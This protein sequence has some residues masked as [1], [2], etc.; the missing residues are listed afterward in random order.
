MTDPAEKLRKE[1]DEAHRSIIELHALIV[2]RD[3]GQEQQNEREL[4]EKRKG[5]LLMLDK[6]E[7]AR[8]QIEQA[9]QEWMAA[10]DAVDDPIFLH[11]KEFRIVRANRAYQRCAGIPFKEIIG[12]PYYQVFPKTDGPLPAC[13][14]TVEE[15][16]KEGNEEEV[17]LGDRIYR[18]RAFPVR[19]EQGDFL[20]SVHSLEDVTE[21]MEMELNLRE[22]EERYRT[23][24]ENM[25]NAFAYCRMVFE[26]GRPVDFIYLD[27]N[28][29]LRETY[30]D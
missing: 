2:K 30:R 7:L 26:E 15:N 28:E 3:R 5:S 6:L 14:R 21:R 24:F 25:L 10:L 16:E 23:L 29:F 1:F 4:E 22:S 17:V 20:Y 19:D 9:H 18:S 8:K 27:V 11:D 13:R 12:R